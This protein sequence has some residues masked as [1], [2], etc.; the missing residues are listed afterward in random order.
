MT[1]WRNYYRKSGN[2]YGNRKVEADGIIFDSV[3]EKRRW[4]ELKLAEAAGAIGDLQRQ[5]R[6]ELIPAQREPDT[7]GPKGGVIKGRLIERKVEYVA[8][9]VYIDLQTGEKVVEDVKG[10][11]EGTAYAVFKIKRKL[12]LERFGIR[13]KEV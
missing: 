13:V 9:F 3:K 4:D 6:F 8:D 10:M 11:R 2:K 5:V 12:M 1:A 7:R